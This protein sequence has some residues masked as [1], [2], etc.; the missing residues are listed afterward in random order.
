[1]K[2]MKKRQKKEKAPPMHLGDANHKTAHILASAH[3]PGLKH[4]G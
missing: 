3:Q 4:L 2:A 1:V